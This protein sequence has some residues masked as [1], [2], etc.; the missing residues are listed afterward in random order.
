MP[1]VQ[2]KVVHL[3]ESAAPGSGSYIKPSVA[4]AELIKRPFRIALSHGHKV[5]GGKSPSDLLPS[6][7]R[8]QIAIMK[9][10]NTEITI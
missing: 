1:R 7:Q 8:K 6:M 2:H 9:L 3:S 4:D 10:S 5:K